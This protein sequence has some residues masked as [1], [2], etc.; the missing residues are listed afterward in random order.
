VRSLLVIYDLGGT[1]DRP[2]V[3]ARARRKIGARREW[4]Q[5]TETAWVVKT[6]ET[7]EQLRDAVLGELGAEDRVFVAELVGAAA[8]HNAICPGVWLKEHL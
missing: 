6:D 2:G 4:A 1:D 7:P 5:V 3:H 8:W